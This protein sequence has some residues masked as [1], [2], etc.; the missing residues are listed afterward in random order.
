MLQK[1]LI[2]LKRVSFDIMLWCFCLFILISA[3]RFE[4]ISAPLQLLVFK[5]MQ[6]SMGFLHAHILR[7]LAFRHADWSNDSNFAIK[8]LIIAL[9]VIIIYAYAR[10]G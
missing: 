10:G 8:A 1:I 4:S 3:N 9:Y 2:E 6:V 7:K 5:A